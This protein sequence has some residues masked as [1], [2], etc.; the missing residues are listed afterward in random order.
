MD[1]INLQYTCE[2][3]FVFIMQILYFTSFSEYIYDDSN[4]I[5]IISGYLLASY[6]ALL[7]CIRKKIDCKIVIKLIFVLSLMIITALSSEGREF[8]LLVVY[9]IV[10][11]DADEKKIM[12]SFF[13]GNVAALIINSILYLMLVYDSNYLNHQTF[14]TLGFQN[15]NFLGL[16]IFDL[17]AL[18]FLVNKKNL[19]KY[20][21]SV[22][23]GMFCWLFVNCR[24]ASIAIF[25]LLIL[26]LLKKYIDKK[27]IFL[28]FVRYSYV[29]LACISIYIGQIGVSNS[30][31]LLLNEVLSGRVVAWNEY[32]VQKPITMFG[33]FFYASDFYALDNAFL[34]LLF[35]YG[36]VVFVIYG[37]ANYYAA[38]KAIQQGAFN[39]QVVILALLFY[40]LMEFSP[41]S[42]FNHIG[43]AMLSTK[44]EQTDD[45][46]ATKAY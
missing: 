45:V 5:I 20:L 46:V 2:E 41:M 37:I 22:L 21:V 19:N 43:L 8:L 35:R 9:F 27:K 42:V 24:T 34:W 26:V 40:S 29:I 39:M 30:I 13:F 12:R 7:T 1:K 36:F 3:I 17:V 28:Q 32:F 33:T 18:C 11:K 23:A 15:S 38:K 16:L 6:F 25:I 31:L 4:R 14:M 44:S 10:L